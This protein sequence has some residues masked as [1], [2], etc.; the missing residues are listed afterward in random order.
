[1]AFEFEHLE[2]AP[3]TG[4]A[5]CVVILLHGYGSNKERAFE[6]APW[7]AAAFPDAQIYAADGT[8]PFVGLLDPKSPNMSEEPTDGRRVWYHRYSEAT[9]QEGLA[10]TRSKLDTYIDECADAAGLGR[11]RVAVIGMSQGAITLLNS[12][13]FIERPFGAAVCHSGYLFS[14][15]SLAQRQE[16]LAEFRAAVVG[17]TPVCQIHGY[18]DHTLP[19]QTDLEAAT[20][21]DECGI[22][23]EFHLLSGL[24]HAEFEL[25]SQA[26]AVEFIR[27]Q[28]GY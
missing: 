24:R 25:R 2:R 14:P 13:P 3:A 18:L 27:R 4:K 15:D 12:V 20:L 16:Q 19:Y 22:P 8:F 26:I 1:M 5:G 23:T 28:L 7:V 9:R 6:Q 21:F 10:E 17:K 11:E